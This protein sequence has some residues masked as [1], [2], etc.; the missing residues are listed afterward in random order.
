MGATLA[1]DSWRL[2]LGHALR[3]P[4]PHNVQP[5]RVRILDA[6][7]AE[8]LIEKRRTLPKE[9][10]TGSFIILTMGMFVEAL[11][12]VAAHHGLGFDEEWVHE[13]AWYAAENLER[14][15]QALIPFARLRLR[16]DAPPAPEIADVTA[17]LAARRTSRL[18]YEPTPVAAEVGAQ[19]AAVAQRGGHRYAQTSDPS[20]IGRLLAF[21]I[22]AVF[23]DLNHPPYCEE[24]AGWLR[25]S[26][27]ASR[28]HR[29]GLDAR[30]MNVSP[31]ELWTTFHLPW[32]LR[33]PALQPWFRRRYRAQIGPVATLGFLCGPFWDPRDAAATGR[34]L[35]HFW[36]ECTR[37][38]LS[39]H[40]YGNL[41]TNRPTAAR[42]RTETGL[43]DVWLAFKIGHSAPPPASRRRAVEEI[44]A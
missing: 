14:V 19:L 1:Q 44:L 39:I 9:D 8:L 4:S 29:D 43:D 28:R 40:P 42:V 6:R 32:L 24:L 11:R 23:E 20:R 33:F 10:V 41:V 18:P 12:L 31:L 2:L 35:L 15:G 17:L 16:A 37:L 5:W 13:P 27:R 38:G 22:E 3:A 36:L 30:C 7:Q 21:N 25:Y 26:E 34:L